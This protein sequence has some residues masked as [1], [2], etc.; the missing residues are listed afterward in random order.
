M[1][2]DMNASGLGGDVAQEGVLWEQ[3]GGWGPVLIPHP[4]AAQRGDI[5]PVVR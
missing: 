1:F 4:G 5:L 2:G 3:Q